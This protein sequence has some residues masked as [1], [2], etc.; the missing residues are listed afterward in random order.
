VNSASPRAK[1]EAGLVAILPCL[2]RFARSLGCDRA[3]A[4]DLV[5]QTLVAALAE[6]EACPAGTAF[7]DWMC[8]IEREAFRSEARRLR[9][10]QELLE[11]VAA[12]GPSTPILI[13]G[14]TS[15]DALAAVRTLPAAMMRAV[16]LALFEGR[17]YCEIAALERTATGTIKSRVSRS[18]TV[19]RELLTTG[20]PPSAACPARRAYRPRKEG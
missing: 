6:W 17:S 7:A 16:L 3:D 14:A 19:V 5:Q 11:I 2:H 4:E 13:H 15:A 20:D 12:A 10:H 18:R 1:F 9:E 8:A